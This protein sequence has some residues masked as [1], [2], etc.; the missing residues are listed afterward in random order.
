MLDTL[1]AQ[2][3]RNAL[4]SCTKTKTIY[5]ADYDLNSGTVLAFN[6][7]GEPLS[8]QTLF[9]LDLLKKSDLSGRVLFHA[10]AQLKFNRTILSGNNWPP[11]GFCDIIPATTE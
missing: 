7:K 3:L 9:A 10:L 2:L 8:R 1:L 11:L 5:L 4:G 6:R